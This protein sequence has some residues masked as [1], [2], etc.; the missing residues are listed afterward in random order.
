M[1][2][3]FLTDADSITGTPGVDRLTV[4]YNF[5]DGG[6]SLTNLSGTLASGYS[7]TFNGT[8]T[9]DVNFSGIENFSFIDQG[10]GPDIIYTGD[11]DDN[12]SGGAGND[13][14]A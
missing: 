13:D 9:N 11:G 7:G 4:T 6:V 3:F 10:S 5:D 12:L 14:L 8:G 2:N 1:S